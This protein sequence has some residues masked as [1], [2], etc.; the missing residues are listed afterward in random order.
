MHARTPHIRAL[1]VAARSDAM[2]APG[3]DIGELKAPIN[4]VERLALEARRLSR[5]RRMGKRDR[6]QQQKHGFC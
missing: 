3:A 2:P 5:R 1:N 6:A 4:A